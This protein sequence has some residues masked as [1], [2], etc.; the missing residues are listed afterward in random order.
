M[1]I[2]TYYLMSEI[3]MNLIM[4]KKCLF[5]F[6]LGV[7]IKLP[8]LKLLSR[9]SSAF[10]FYTKQFINVDETEASSVCS[11]LFVY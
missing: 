2:L 7:R 6:T 1:K 10:H 9:T 11:G 3:L 4:R 8:H 5:I